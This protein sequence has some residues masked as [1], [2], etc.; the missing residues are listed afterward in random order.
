METLYIKLNI[1]KS[2][3]QTDAIR[4]AGL[5]FENIANAI[6]LDRNN[7]QEI[8]ESNFRI[9]IENIQNKYSK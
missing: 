1:S 4:D 9:E 2:D 8:D 3:S 6:S 5:L 7:I